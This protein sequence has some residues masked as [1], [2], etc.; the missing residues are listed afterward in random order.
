MKDSKSG[1]SQKGFITLLSL[2]VL[3][4]IISLASAYLTAGSK[5][6]DIA[7]LLLSAD[8]AR[9]ASLAGSRLAAGLLVQDAVSAPA[10]DH[11]GE[12]WYLV[13]ENTA[14]T[15]VPYALDSN[16]GIYFQVL[17]VDMSGRYKPNATDGVT[18]AS[19]IARLPNYGTTA[20]NGCVSGNYWTVSEFAFV[21]NLSDDRVTGVSPYGRDHR[22]NINTADIRDPITAND[23]PDIINAM[24]K[25]VAGS[26]S[27][28]AN[29]YSRKLLRSRRGGAGQDNNAAYNPY[30]TDNNPAGVATTLGAWSTYAA[31]FTTPTTNIVQRSQINW[32]A[33]T[34]G[35]LN[36]E[37]FFLI[38]SS[39]WVVKDPSAG[40]CPDPTL[41]C[42]ESQYQVMRF[43]KRSSTGYQDCASREWYYE[44]RD[45]PVPPYV[46]N[47]SY[48][49]ENSFF[50]YDSNF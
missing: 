22:V 7:R 39:G 14:G 37:G 33:Q 24:M 48:D 43:V 15:I 49:Y 25:L 23:P 16:Q 5:E 13:T 44:K 1:R 6:V 17:V 38:K 34:F 8:Q 27:T 9:L 3:T 19:M 32:V 11:H 10:E 36:S 46:V 4:F 18:A 41:N 26:A 42:R 31:A 12:N 20:A 35:R 28:K 47:S 50:I 45:L 30:A 29:T 40:S 2:V 21:T